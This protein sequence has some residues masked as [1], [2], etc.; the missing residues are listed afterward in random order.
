MKRNVLFLL[1]LLNAQYSLSI[2]PTL[3]YGTGLISGMTLF[4]YG[5]YGAILRVKLES[6][7]EGYVNGAKETLESLQFELEKESSMSMSLLNNKIEKI[8]NFK[9]NFKKIKPKM[10]RF[11][12]PLLLS[13][14][15]FL[16]AKYSYDRL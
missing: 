10:R 4:L 14:A 7:N 15:G 16:L 13:T 6:I 8:N 2:D 5:I 9:D 3:K 1:I 11:K 12:V